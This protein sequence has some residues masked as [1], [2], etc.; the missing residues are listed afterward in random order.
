[1][2]NLK[3]NYCWNYICSFRIVDQKYAIF[4]SDMLE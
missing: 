1:M 2:L 4:P 3:N